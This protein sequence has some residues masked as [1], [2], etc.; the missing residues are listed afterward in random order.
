[1]K[2]NTKNLCLSAFFAVVIAM[3]AFIKI[4]IGIVPMTLQTMT[5][6]LVALVL[7]AKYGFLSVLLYIGLGLLGLPVFANGAGLSYVLQ[8][9]FGY[10]LGFLATSVFVGYCKTK[11]NSFASLLLVC[12]IGLGILYFCGISYYVFLQIY[13]YQNYFVWPYILYSF[14]L[15]FIPTDLLSCVIAIQLYK[16]IKR[17]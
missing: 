5:V 11:I 17:K 16:R 7:G 8:P 13:V 10:L 9:S 1:M 2:N 14:A 12:S 6:M 4:P 15:V 3:S